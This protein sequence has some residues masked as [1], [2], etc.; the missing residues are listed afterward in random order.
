MA[1]V[2]LESGL[3]Y[4][5]IPCYILRKS[6]GAIS[7]VEAY[8]AME[9]AGHFGGFIMPLNFPEE[10]PEDLYEEGEIW[11]IYAY[12]DFFHRI[13]EKFF[14]EGYEACLADYNLEKEEG[15]TA[16]IGCNRVE[17][18]LREE[19][20]AAERTEMNAEDVIVGCSAGAR[21]AALGR[22]LDKVRK[23]K[24]GNYETD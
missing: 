15:R 9:K 21:K 22:V 17:Q 4:M 5:G 2:T 1:K 14:N 23:W 16:L 10:T 12:D 3:D 18:W 19:I 24:E 7:K 8:E 6:K 13:Q 20:E 11:E